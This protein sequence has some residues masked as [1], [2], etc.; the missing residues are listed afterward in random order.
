M[1]GIRDAAWARSKRQN[2]CDGA[3]TGGPSLGEVLNEIA[4]VASYY[5]WKLLQW[6]NDDVIAQL[7]RRGFTV[8]RT[9]NGGHWHYVSWDD[10]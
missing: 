3:L 6:L 4:A 10:D 5:P 8:K 2:K 7:E 1:F 9:V